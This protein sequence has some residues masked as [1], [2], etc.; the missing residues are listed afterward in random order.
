VD[1]DPTNQQF[2]GDRYV[3]VAWG[4]DYTDIPPLK[5]VIFTEGT[6]HELT[7]DVDVVALGPA[8][9]G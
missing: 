4:R 6:E 5:G 2:V 7:V 9:S 3:T 1:I 8:G